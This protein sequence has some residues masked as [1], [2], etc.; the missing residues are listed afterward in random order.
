MKRGTFAVSGR[1]Q[2][3]LYN[4]WDSAFPFPC[5]RHDEYVE[6]LTLQS[7]PAA[8]NTISTWGYD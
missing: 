5:Q 6:P 2:A 4:R 1:L 8:H 7:R 3:R